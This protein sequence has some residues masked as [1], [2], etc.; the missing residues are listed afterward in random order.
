[1]SSCEVA[2]NPVS[3]FDY[4]EALSRFEND[5]QLMVE[6][7]ELF[8]DDCPRRLEAMHEAMVAGDL[9]ALEHTGHSFRGSAANFGALEVVSAALQLETLARAGDLQQ[10]PAAAAAL[11]HEIERLVGRLLS[12]LLPER[13]ATTDS[14]PPA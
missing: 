4:D 13:V 12:E 11:E 7:A 2:Q 1:M 10:T 8:V 9:K 3:V 14:H 6:V 5:F